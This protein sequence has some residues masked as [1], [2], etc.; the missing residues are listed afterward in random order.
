MIFFPFFTVC[1][2]ALK[3]YRLKQ[4]QKKYQINCRKK[5]KNDFENTHTHTHTQKNHILGYDYA[6][7]I[8]AIWHTHTHTPNK[9]NLTECSTYDDYGDGDVIIGCGIGLWSMIQKKTKSLNSSSNNN[10]KKTFNWNE[11]FFFRYSIQ[12]SIFFSFFRSKV[13]HFFFFVVLWIFT[14][15]THQSI[16]GEMFFCKYTEKK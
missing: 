10:N 1:V 3:N 13:A 2:C 5:K 8:R 9:P 6:W 14:T 4:Q 16:D 7:P 15:H 11:L 12:W